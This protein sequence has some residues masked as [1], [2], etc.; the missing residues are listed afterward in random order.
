MTGI[1]V[2]DFFVGLVARAHEYLTARQDALQ[3]EF[4]LGSWPRWDWDQDTGELVFSRDGV[5]HVVADFQFVGS[6]STV[7]DTWRW[8]AARPEPAAP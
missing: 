5:P 6:I 8:V 1:E 7:S 3:R 4:R 2:T